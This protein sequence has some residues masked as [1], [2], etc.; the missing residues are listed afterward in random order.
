MINEIDTKKTELFMKNFET[1]NNNFKDIFSTL[2][3]KGEASLVL[4]NQDTPLEGGLMV[5]VRLT[6]AFLIGPS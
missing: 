1:I 5:K 4:E 3:T 2:S 6:G